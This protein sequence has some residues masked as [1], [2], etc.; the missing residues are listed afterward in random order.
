M[1]RSTI[2][3]ATALAG[4]AACGAVASAA[5]AKGVFADIEGAFEA[6][7]DVGKV[8]TIIRQSF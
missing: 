3:R 2:R 5:T 8:A 6:N 7:H 1:P 4:L